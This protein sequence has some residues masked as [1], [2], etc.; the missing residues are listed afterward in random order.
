MKYAWIERQRGSYSVRL[1]C[2]ALKVTE[3]GYYQ[4]LKAPESRRDNRREVLK[5][6]VRSEYQRQRQRYG[7]PRI[8]RELAAQGVQCSERLVADIMR[9]EGLRARGARKFRAT[10]NSA[11]KLPVAANVVARAFTVEAP[12]DVWAGD[13]TYL[14]TREGWLYLAVFLDLFSRRVV[15]WALAKTL[16]TRLV[17]LAF[18]R[19]VARRSPG[20]GLVVHSDRGV[21]YASREFRDLLAK[22]KAV[23]SMSRKGDCWD[24]AVVE[25]F[26]HSLKVEA[27]HG[28]DFVTRKEAEFEVFDY[29]ERF[30]NKTRRHSYLGFLA[31]ETFEK[32]KLRAMG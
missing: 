9:Q 17:S 25:S 6:R 4:W 18:Q 5:L 26:F 30:Y 32:Q 23:Q 12:N 10:T 14:W 22:H 31:P 20:A 7:S 19:A 24:N 21:Q 15:G 29:I 16:D 2:N 1:L 28:L 3:Q 13:I 11:H 27:I 8:H